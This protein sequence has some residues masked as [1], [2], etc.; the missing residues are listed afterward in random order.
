MHKSRSLLFIDGELDLELVKIDSGF[1]VVI[2]NAATHY[3]SI[4]KNGTFRENVVGTDHTSFDSI[5]YENGTIRAKCKTPVTL[6]VIIYTS[7]G[8]F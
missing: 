1:V 3:I 4:S 7:R 5:Y 8:S 6:D 2:F